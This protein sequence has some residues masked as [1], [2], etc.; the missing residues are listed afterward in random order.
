VSQ[1]AEDTVSIA[2]ITGLPTDTY[3]VRAYTL[4][5]I[6]TSDN[7]VS[8]SLGNT[9]GMMIDLV[10]GTKVQMTLTFKT[11][12][13][14]TSIDTYRYNPA[15]VPVRVEV[16]DSFGALVGANATY[17]PGDSSY[18]VE[19]VG[20]H[21]YAGNPCSR[22][23]N[24]YDTTDGWLQKD[25]GLPAGAYRVMVWVPG[26]TQLE[27]IIISTSPGGSAGV[28]FSLERLS[29][30]FGNVS[31]LNMYEDLIPLSWATVSAYGVTLSSTSSQDGFYEMWLQNGTHMLAASSLGYETQAVEVY[32][33]NGSETPLDFDL[34][35]SSTAIPELYLTDLTFLTILIIS[36]TLLQRKK[37]GSV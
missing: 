15:E 35:P 36:Y 7:P 27:T 16:Y 32:A 14:V 29:C 8:V 5:Y 10:K 1:Q 2:N 37:S 34:K 25:Y 6:Q 22:W 9:G 12:G 24:F 23:T 19:V 31:G 11:A 26:Y 4:G 17:V 28:T 21:A 33:S 30:V 13:L 20:F 18:T 3:L